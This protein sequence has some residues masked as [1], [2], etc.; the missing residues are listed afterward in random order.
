MSRLEWVQ[1]STVAGWMIVALAV[2]CGPKKDA[3]RPKAR[4]PDAEYSMRLAQSQFRGGR[5]TEALATLDEAIERDPDIAALYN[6]YGLFCLQ[7]GRYEKAVV[8]LNE[9]LRVDPFLTDAHN[10]LG[11]VYLELGQ[12][13]EAEGEFRAA[14]DDPAY[15][16][17]EKVYLNLGLLYKS[18]GRDAE[19]ISALR[20]SVGIDPT[21]YKAHYQL[22]SMLERLGKILEA[23]REYEVAEPGFKNDGEYWY[24]RGFSYYR[25]GEEGKA[26]DAL[27]RV[28]SIAPGSESAAKADKLLALMTD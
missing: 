24:R 5:V 20:K 28:R 11:T 14:L 12:I 23:A 8:A 15:P 18:Q 1:R 10:N 3:D 26:L 16:T 9:A 2:G 7:S 27:Y 19:S 4:E 17:P 21:Y 25:L 6:F 22:A 13:N